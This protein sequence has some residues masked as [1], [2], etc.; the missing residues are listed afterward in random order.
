MAYCRANCR[1]RRLLSI[2]HMPLPSNRPM[3]HE[4]MSAHSMCLPSTHSLLAPQSLVTAGAAQ[5]VPW[6]AVGA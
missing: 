6:G 4:F 1:A 5:G 3:F 2:R